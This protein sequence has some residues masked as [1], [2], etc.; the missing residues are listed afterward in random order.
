M[1]QM[2]LTHFTRL[3]VYHPAL[4]DKYAEVIQSLCSQNK[5]EGEAM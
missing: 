3:M 1:G 5:E 2:K 4:L